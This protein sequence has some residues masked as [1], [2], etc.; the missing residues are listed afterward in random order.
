MLFCAKRESGCRFQ[1]KH[2]NSKNGF[3]LWL[4]L[5]LNDECC[6]RI[7]TILIRCRRHEIGQCQHH[8]VFPILRSFTS[9]R[10]IALLLTFSVDTSRTREGVWG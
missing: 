9:E 3:P 4:P 6:E 1:G 8:T 2:G 10:P 5:D 7:F